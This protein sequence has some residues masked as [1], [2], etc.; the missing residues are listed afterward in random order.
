MKNYKYE[1]DYELVKSYKKGDKNASALLLEKYRPFLAKTYKS[2]SLR[3]V[4]EWA[5]FKQ[6]SFFMILGVLDWVKEEK[7]VPNF[8]IIHTLKS[9]ISNYV[10]R[11]RT[12]QRKWNSPN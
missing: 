5:D 6:D 7:L 10:K 9:Q 12:S 1:S 8:L 3:R 2:Y 11:F 4:V